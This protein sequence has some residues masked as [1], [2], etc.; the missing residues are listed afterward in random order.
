[1]KKFAFVEFAMLV[2]SILYSYSAALATPPALTYQGRILKTDGSPLEYSSVSFIFKIMDP[3]GQCLLYQEQVNSIDM[4][5]SGGVFDVPIGKG[6]VSFPKTGTF[7]VL[8]AFNNNV[9]A[10]TCYG[11]TTYNPVV[12]DGRLLRVSFYDGSGWKT[13]TPDNSIRSVP[14]AGHAL[15]AQKLGDNVAS[16][17]LTKAGIPNCTAG[18]FLTWNGTSLTCAAAGAAGGTITN[19]SGTAPINVGTGTSTPVVSLANGTAAG[20]V[21]RWDGTSSWVSTKLK[22]TDL[23]NGTA[24]NPWP[25]STCATGQAVTWSSA[26]DSFS[27]STLSIATNQLSGTLAAAQMPAFS[28]DVSSST[29]ST[30]LTLSNS[31]VAAGTYTSVTVDAKGRVTSGTSPTTLSGYGITDAVKNLGGVGNMSAGTDVS[32][33]VTANTGDLFVATDTQK[34]YRFNG[35]SWDLISSSGG[36]GG[37]VTS[38]TAGT[39]LTGGTIT[40]S[41]TI[42]LGTELTGLNGLSTTGFVRRTAAG[43]YSTST[44]VNLLADVAGTLPVTNGG[45]GQSTYTDGQLLIGNTATGS[46]SKSAL[47]AG[48]GI[49]ITNGNGSITIA[50]TGLTASSA[51]SGDVS[52]TSTTTSV[53]KIKGTAVSATAPTSG[54]FLIYDGSTQYSAVSMSGDATMVNDGTVTLK[55]TGTAGTYY[56]VTTDAQGRVTSGSSLVPGDITTAL[57]YTPLNKAGD[58][59]TGT[60][61]VFTTA[62]DPAGLVAGD[63]G[64]VWYNTTS[65]QL[66]YWDG[67]A[68]Q[69]LGIAGT[70]MTSLNGQ[71]GSTQTFATPGTSGTAPSWSSATNAHTLNIPMASGAGVT[72]GLISKTDYDTFNNKIDSS[73]SF[74]GDVSGTHSA[75]SV[76]KIK[77][78]TVSPV[79]YSAGQVLRYDGTNWV[80]AVIDAATDLSGMVPVANG[81]T[82]ANFLGTGNLLVGAGTGAVTSLAAGSAGNVVYATGI[83]SWSSGTPDAAGLVDKSSTQTISGAK[84][85][86]NYVQINAQNE[87]RFADADS[88]NYVALRSPSTVA[89]NVTW[90]LPAT[91]GTAGQILKTDG[92]GNLSW[93]NAS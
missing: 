83:S 66:K 11:G 91:D 86:S 85:F 40:N 13:I 52:G 8:D 69:P 41:G 35:A 43:A 46:L 61:G 42:G 26:S 75:T 55:N 45:T 5:N 78:K 28:G 54:Q 36:S 57:G 4:T 37:T 6:S 81:G 12:T 16:D 93:V 15:T 32:K 17:F 77:G 73:A 39:G 67:S 89:A 88:S 76:D 56:K 53:D 63:K 38:I 82:G 65:N 68:A 7:T 48:T 31:G 9:T 27:C 72:A 10:H 30:A 51:F 47:T 80:N 60:L 33:P 87:V 44:S 70:G 20:E 74:S 34:I 23:V 22:Y 92:A 49:S 18:T 14:Y 24:A 79:A 3:T 19:V 58:V 71:T 84:A 64:K 90:T 1:M 50:N 25:I 2:F 21:Y 62:S 59:M 29:G